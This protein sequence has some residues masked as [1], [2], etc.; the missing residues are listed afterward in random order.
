[1]LKIAVLDDE[2][3][4]IRQICKETEKYFAKTDTPYGFYDYIDYKQLLQDVESGRD[5]DL[6]LLDV[7]LGDCSG[8][9]VARRIRQRDNECAIVCVTN[10]T[11][12][13]IAAYEVN[14]FRYIMKKD[15]KEKL[16][17]MYDAI[18]P[19]L[20]ERKERFYA[21]RL[22]SGTERLYYN[23]IMYLTRDKKYVVFHMKDKREV[24]VRGTLGEIER[25]LADKDF[26]W[27]DKGCIINLNQLEA[28]EDSDC[29]MR[30]GTV[31][32]I[33]RARSRELRD[34]MMGIGNIKRN[35]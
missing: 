11:E 8:L 31:L 18:V 26:M 28:W 29:R 3:G 20:V 34:R 5:F 30:D 16:P 23:K 19:R 35:G 12:Y 13:A 7:E 6:F 33:S 2:R 22:S 14:A 9:D 1:M 24:R 10:Y 25:E 27:I 15:L 4:Y 32:G 17:E 21:A